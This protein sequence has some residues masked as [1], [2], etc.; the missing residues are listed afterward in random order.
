MALAVAQAE[1]VEAGAPLPLV[2]ITRPSATPSSPTTRALFYVSISFLMVNHVM[3]SS[4][5]CPVML[6]NH[7]TYRGIMLAYECGGVH[8]VTPAGL[9][10]TIDCQLG[11][12]FPGF[13]LLA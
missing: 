5:V 7:T 4:I 1:A 8:L 10:G 9:Y 11:F 3:R 13:Y 12:V 6:E 2:A